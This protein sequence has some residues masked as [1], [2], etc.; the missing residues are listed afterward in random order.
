M[1]SSNENSAYGPVRN[2]WDPERVPGGSSGGSA[3]AVAAGLA[4]C[5]IG[6]DTGG[7]IRQ[8]AALCGVVGL[9]PTYGR[10][11]ASGVIP[12]SW[13]QDHVGPMA[14]TAEDAAL[15][16]AAISDFAPPDLDAPQGKLRV[17]LCREVFFQRMDPEVRTLVD[18]AIGMLGETSEVQIPHIGV[19][20]PVQALIT[21]SEAVAFHRHWI[22]T[23]MDDYDWSIRNRLESGFEV[24]G[25]DY[26]Y[27]LRLRGLIAHEMGQ[28]LEAVDVLAMPTVV[29][30]APKFGQREAVL[31]D[32]V[33]EAVGPLMLRNASAMN[34]SGF[35]A[36][37]VP[38]G[39][40]STGL[41]VG[42]QLVARPWQEARL[43]Q[44]AHA[45]EPQLAA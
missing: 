28:A 43:L 21:S 15:L 27:A 6:T 14:A 20:A 18:Q 12:L 4:P 40:T 42:L 31:E 3:A 11:P 2:P 25:A 5:S 44:I 26:A 38:C 22:E 36:I 9:K 13:S 33:A 19:A 39:K 34:V 45:L 23:R 35:P 7:S 16:L 30:P 41:P 32:G 8:P 1:G 17:G 37:T 24:T 29:V 10:V